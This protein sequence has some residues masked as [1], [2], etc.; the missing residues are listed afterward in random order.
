VIPLF[1]QS[2]DVHYW[3]RAG[4]WLLVIFVMAHVYVA[5]REDIMSRQTMVSTMINGWRFF[6][7]DRKD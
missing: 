4:F 6:K 7:D 5:V 3:H 1:G 2:L